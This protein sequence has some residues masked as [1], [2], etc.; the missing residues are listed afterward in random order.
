MSSRPLEYYVE[1][2][3]RLFT[4]RAHIVL[5]EVV[6]LNCTHRYLPVSCRVRFSTLTT[7]L[8]PKH[9]L[10]IGLTVGFSLEI[11]NQMP[12]NPRAYEYV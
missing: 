2:P 1:S 3:S 12:I 8:T 10:D 6:R 7:S 11:S 9:G 5:G 4:T